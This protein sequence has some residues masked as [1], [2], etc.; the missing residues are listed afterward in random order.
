MASTTSESDDSR[1]LELIAGKNQQPVQFLFT[2]TAFT[3]RDSLKSMCISDSTLSLFFTTFTPIESP[4]AH[5]PSSH[6][7]SVNMSDSV[8]DAHVLVKK[9]SGLKPVKISGSFQ[10]DH[11]EASSN[12]KDWVQ[13]AMSAA[14]PGTWKGL[15]THRTTNKVFC[16]PTRYSGAYSLLSIRM[17]AP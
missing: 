1:Q 9:R 4:I 8:V 5:V 17:E 15:C 7:L 3:V 6:V 2:K 12:A 13:G 16:K 11:S 14:Y 10:G